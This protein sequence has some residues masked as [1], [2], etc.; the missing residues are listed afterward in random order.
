MTNANSQRTTTSLKHPNFIQSHSL[1]GHAIT[2]V[3]ATCENHGGKTS[4]T[5]QTN[6]WQIHPHPVLPK[7]HEVD[8]TM[9]APKKARHGFNDLIQRDILYP[10]VSSTVN[11]NIMPWCIMYQE[12]LDY[13]PWEGKQNIPT[14]PSPSSWCNLNLFRKVQ[15]TWCNRQWRCSTLPACANWSSGFLQHMTSWLSWRK[16]MSKRFQTYGLFSMTKACTNRIR[17]FRNGVTGATHSDCSSVLHFVT[18][19]HVCLIKTPNK[20]KSWWQSCYP[21]TRLRRRL[22]SISKGSRAC[23]LQRLMW[24]FLVINYHKFMIWWANISTVSGMHSIPECHGYA[25]QVFRTSVAF[26]TLPSIMKNIKATLPCLQNWR[27]AT[28]EYL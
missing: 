5:C 15:G 3:S 26:T 12:F 4:A 7:L 20:Y 18:R 11:R 16:W 9:S 10:S 22:G 13:V 14:L 8:L 19:I 25:H 17:R 6:V 28:L 27:K 1:S 24:P 21:W 23:T 2:F